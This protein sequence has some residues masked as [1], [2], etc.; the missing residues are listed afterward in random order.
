MVLRAVKLLPERFA[1]QVMRAAKFCSSCGERM[2]VSG[3]LFLPTRT[4]CARCA[5]RFRGSGLK[6]IFGLL[7][8]ASLAFL[9]GRYTA[10]D[11]PFHFIGAPIDISS[12]STASMQSDEA[13]SQPIEPSLSQAPASTGASI[14]GAATRSGKPCQ[15]KVQGGGYCHQHRAAEQKRQEATGGR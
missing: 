4:L 8:V 7:I 1:I 2:I 10:P 11:R 6:I 9:V 3:K 13:R 12:R 14:C 5:P 15:R